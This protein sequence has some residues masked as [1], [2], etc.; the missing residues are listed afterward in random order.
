[1]SQK[2]GLSGKE[3]W[4]GVYSG[5]GENPFCTL[6]RGI[7]SLFEQ[8]AHEVPVEKFLAWGNRV[9]SGLNL[10]FIPRLNVTEDGQQIA[11]TIELP[12][13]AEDQFELAVSKDRL[14]IRGE[15][16]SDR[17]PEGGR[18]LVSECISGKF[19]RVVDFQVEIDPDQVQASFA[20]GVLRVTIPKMHP[21]QERKVNIKVEA[22]H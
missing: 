14:V 10:A 15:K 22:D 18:R 3:K 5:E 17:V 1:M 20:G 12:G 7:N 11:V 4:R 19:E 6:Q 2:D 13:I 21:T 16:R 9:S 8:F